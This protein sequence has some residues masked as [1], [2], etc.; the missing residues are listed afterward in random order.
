LVIIAVM[1]AGAYAMGAYVPASAP[2]IVALW[3]TGDGGRAAD[4]VEVLGIRASVLRSVRSRA[5]SDAAWGRALRVVVE[6]GS[7]STAMPHVIGRYS[8]QGDRVRFDPRFPFVP[9]VRYRV[10][11][12]AGALE[13]LGGI[14]GG[15]DT[16]RLTHRF[17][18]PVQAPARRTRVVAV[19]PAVD[20]VPSNMLR[21]YLEFSSAM[22][23][24]AAH[25]HVR[26]LD[27]VGRPVEAAFLSVDEELW[28]P[29]RKRLTLFF[30]PGRVKRG[31]RANVEMGAPLIEGHRYRLVVDAAWRDAA[32]A[33]LASGFEKEFEAVAVDGTSPDPSRWTIA[34]PRARTR[35]A[36]RITFGEPLDH[37]LAQRM[38]TVV[39]GGRTLAGGV[40]LAAGDSVWSFIPESPWRPGTYQLRV[41]AALEDIAGNSVARVF[42]ADR[43]RGAAGAEESARG[44]AT[45]ML[46]VRIRG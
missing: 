6:Q 5:S 46:E 28:D 8:V 41:D 30:D 44:G 14:G 17:A 7:E 25:E 39:G 13:A 24:G 2:R 21:W 42:D 15:G 29:S 20:R 12:D 33:A 45:R 1:L 31:V 43:R 16:T 27:E 35:D 36:L 34:T 4:A 22:E 11:F 3:G 38:V 23:P 40:D 19:H 32:G 37:A 26:L 9:G 18:T 10:E